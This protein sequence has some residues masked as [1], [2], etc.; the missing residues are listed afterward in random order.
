MAKLEP[1]RQ[2]TGGRKKG[3][4]NKITALLRD[5]ILQAASAAHPGG[6]VGYLT[7]QA[8]ENPTAFLTLLGKVLPMQVQGTDGGPLQVVIQRFSKED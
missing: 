4:P 1:G 3:T 2:R 5:E 7:Q 8:Q 6:R